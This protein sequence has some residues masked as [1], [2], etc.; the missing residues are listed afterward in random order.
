MGSS[1][2]SIG[3]RAAVTLVETGGDLQSPGGSLTLVCKASGF[4]LSSY[5][6]GWM[7]Q[8]PGQGLDG[9]TTRYAPSVQGR[10]TISRDNSQSTVTL[11]MSSLTTE[12]TAT[13][14][15]AKAYGSGSAGAAYGGTKPRA[16]SQT[17]PIGPKP[18]PL[19][20]NGHNSPQGLALWPESQ[21]FWAQIATICSK[22][23]IFASNFV[24]TLVQ[25]S[26]QLTSNLDLWTSKSTLLPQKSPI[27]TKYQ[28]FTTKLNL[29]FAPNLKYLP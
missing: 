28:P 1:S 11:Q 17:S 8:A 20:P 13:Y 9:A 5:D 4:T 23:Q 6:M 16:L 21:L 25:K 24:L 2:P 10:F 7:R 18:R 27:C 19:A 15:C 12:D 22:S 14:Y 3:L 26:Q 29:L